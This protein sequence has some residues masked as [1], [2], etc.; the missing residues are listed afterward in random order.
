MSR[1]WVN[2]IYWCLGECEVYN[3]WQGKHAVQWLRKKRGGGGGGG[4]LE[5]PLI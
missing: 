4:G 5:P 3:N 2:L 1:C